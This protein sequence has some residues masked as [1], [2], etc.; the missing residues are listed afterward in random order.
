M[1]R[2]WGDEELAAE[3]VNQF[4]VNSD[5]NGLGVKEGYLS[6]HKCMPGS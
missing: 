2:K 4:S 1:R 5:K 6:V 3:K